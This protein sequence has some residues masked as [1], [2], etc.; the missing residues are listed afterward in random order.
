MNVG[1]GGILQERP[2]VPRTSLRTA[3]DFSEV[4][5][6]TSAV[7]PVDEQGVKDIYGPLL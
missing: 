2:Y 6:S 4:A 5:A 7:P 3:G 1:A